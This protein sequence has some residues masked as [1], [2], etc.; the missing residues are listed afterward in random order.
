MNTQSRTLTIQTT[1]FPTNNYPTTTSSS[2]DRCLSHSL[3]NHKRH[4]IAKVQ[5]K[6]QQM[7]YFPFKFPCFVPVFCL[8]TTSLYSSSNDSRVAMK[9]PTCQQQRYK[10]QQFT[11]NNFPFCFATSSHAA[12]LSFSQTTTA[13]SPCCPQSKML[14]TTQQNSS[15][16]HKQI[17]QRV[18][19]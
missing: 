17:T 13:K 5:P 4:L 11:V 7:P 19:A 1:S 18:D 9:D 8:K 14:D 15:R 3:I 16:R 10:V 12:P 2:T 6:I